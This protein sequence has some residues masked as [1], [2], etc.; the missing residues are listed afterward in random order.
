[1]SNSVGDVRHLP[2]ATRPC[3]LDRVG[4]CLAKCCPISDLQAPSIC[5]PDH[6]RPKHRAPTTWTDS[7]DW[8]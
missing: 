2:G 3:H 4:P 8:A 1:M 5:P 7:G 6:Y